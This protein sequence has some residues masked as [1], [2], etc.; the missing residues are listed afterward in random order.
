KKKTLKKKD[1][2]KERL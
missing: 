1:S 2:K